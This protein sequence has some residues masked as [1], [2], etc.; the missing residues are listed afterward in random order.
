MA[1]K[2]FKDL[3]HKYRISQT[4]VAE[5][6]LTSTN[7]ISH[8]ESGSRMKHEEADTLKYKEILRKKINNVKQ[9]LERRLEEV[10]NDLE[11]LK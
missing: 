2:Q 11:Q 7:T 3:R 5:K 1:I 10:N 4:E 6:L 9:D 8:W